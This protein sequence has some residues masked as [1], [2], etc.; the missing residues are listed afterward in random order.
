MAKL[1]QLWFWPEEACH[2]HVCVVISNIIWKFDEETL[3]KGKVI[4]TLMFLW[5]TDRW[6]KR[7]SRYHLFLKRA[8]QKWQSLNNHFWNVSYLVENKYHYL[9]SQNKENVSLQNRT[10]YK[11]KVKGTSTICLTQYMMQWNNV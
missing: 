1:G 7:S 4:T 9:K 8:T 5:Q 11:Y 3:R 6:T 2:H 10:E